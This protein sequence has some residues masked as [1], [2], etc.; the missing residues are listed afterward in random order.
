MCPPAVQTWR[1]CFGFHLH[2]LQSGVSPLR[3]C[4]CHRLLSILGPRVTAIRVYTC[5]W[6]GRAKD[7]KYHICWEV[8]MYTDL[9]LETPTKRTHISLTTK[10]HLQNLLELFTIQIF[11]IQ[12]S[13]RG[14]GF[15]TSLQGPAWV[16]VACQG[17]L[18]HGSW[19]TQD[20]ATG[21]GGFP[22]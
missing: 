9:P 11:E 4:C 6:W 18:R 19:L 22:L 3:C 15:S 17:L 14:T 2:R 7:A 21:L 1:W 10:T 5:A 16:L 8:I 12:S 20:G 13:N